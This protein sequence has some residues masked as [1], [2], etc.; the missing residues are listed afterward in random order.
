[1]IPTTS[2]VTER[3][4]ESTVSKKPETN[5]SINIISEFPDY[6]G[7]AF[8]EINGNVPFFT[9]SDYTTECFES[10]SDLDVKGRCGVAYACIGIDTIP[11]E[12]RG[13]I[14][15]VKPS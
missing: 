2:P 8:A 5:N 9:Q 11:S 14:G 10:Y 13:A 12:K 1:M 6:S 15:M 4:I 7:S 3:V